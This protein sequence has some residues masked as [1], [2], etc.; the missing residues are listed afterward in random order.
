MR[1]PKMSL[2]T[3]H[4]IECLIDSALD[5]IKSRIMYAQNHEPV[6]R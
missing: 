1:D 3:L 6:M 2:L 4:D 5:A